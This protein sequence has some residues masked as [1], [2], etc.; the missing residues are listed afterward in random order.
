MNER[1]VAELF[2]TSLDE[3]QAGPESWKEHGFPREM[4]IARSIAD[5]DLAP[6]SITLPGLHARI[7]EQIDAWAREELTARRASLPIKAIRFML[8]P[9]PAAVT[10]LLFALV[11]IE[12]AAPGGLSG[13]ERAMQA[14]IVTL[15]RVGPGVSVETLD[16]SKMPPSPG[17]PSPFWKI[18]TPAG[19]I[20]EAVPP[21][22]PIDGWRYDSYEE[23]RANA[24]GFAFLEPTALPEGYQLF[25]VLLSPGK[26]WV[27]GSYSHLLYPV[28]SFAAH[29]F[30]HAGR[31]VMSMSAPREVLRT[32]VNGAPAAWVDGD[33]LVWEKGSVSYALGGGNLTRE[34]AIVIAELL[35]A[36]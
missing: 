7:R 20:G 25:E 31:I 28:I 15:F 14:A 32:A 2:C 27:I 5:L 34:E 22:A 26:D 30:V 8:K 36:K 24:P 18:D 11:L 13:F 17:L 16:Y 4:E 35:G 23:A 33:I 9:V 12:C 3:M 19:K 6:A 29:D 10:A 21:G 1:R